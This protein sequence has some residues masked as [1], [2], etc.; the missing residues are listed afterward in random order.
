VA[1]SYGIGRVE[2]YFFNLRW[3]DIVSSDEFIQY[4]VQPDETVN[5]QDHHA[6]YRVFLMN[7]QCIYI[8]YHSVVIVKH[9][10]VAYWANLAGNTPLEKRR[11]F[12]LLSIPFDITR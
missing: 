7:T 3:I 4:L 1:A 11:D 8:V 6:P 9:L 10:S 2:E 12:F 5:V